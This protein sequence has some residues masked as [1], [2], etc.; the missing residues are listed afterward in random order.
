VRSIAESLEEDFPE[1]L[2]WSI[3]PCIE[4]EGGHFVDG[5][6]AEEEV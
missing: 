5:V 2:R 4:I 3:A 6:D 1:S